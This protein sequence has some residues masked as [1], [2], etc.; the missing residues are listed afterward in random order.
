MNILHC[1]I[2]LFLCSYFTLSTLFKSYIT[3]IKEQVHVDSSEH[4]HYL[5]QFK[6]KIS[7]FVFSNVLSLTFQARVIQVHMRLYSTVVSM[8]SI[9]CLDYRQLSYRHRNIV[10]SGAFHPLVLAFCAGLFFKRFQL[11]QCCCH[12][13]A[14]TISPVKFVIWSFESLMLI[15]VISIY[16]SHVMRKPFFGHC[17]QVRPIIIY[18]TVYICLFQGSALKKKK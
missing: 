3:L 2:W 9:L 8:R 4:E 7:F 12:M 13:P 5:L 14:C 1:Q 16:L 17:N 6:G 10:M 15:I 18:M 11:V